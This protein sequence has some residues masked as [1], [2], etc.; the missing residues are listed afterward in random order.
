MSKLRA[1][2]IFLIEFVLFLGLWLYDDYIGSLLSGIS[3]PIALFL[4]LV[5]Y[6]SEKLEPSRVPRWYFVF[7]ITSFLAPIATALVYLF[8]LGGVEW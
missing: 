3:A 4:L 5:A 7:M 6:I 8:I 2:E 1:V